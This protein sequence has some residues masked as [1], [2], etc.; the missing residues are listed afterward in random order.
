MTDLMSDERAERMRRDYAE[1]QA[2]WLARLD[3]AKLEGPLDGRERALISAAIRNVADQ[4]MAD[5][6][7]ED[8]RFNHDF[9]W[10]GQSLAGSYPT[11]LIISDARGSIYVPMT[12]TDGAVR[13]D[14]REQRLSHG[15]SQPSIT[16]QRSLPDAGER[17]AKAF[18]EIF[19]TFSVRAR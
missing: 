1:S 18:E 15:R 17:L 6:R 7:K 11:A 8:P 9:E 16:I 2:K 19:W 5:R 10:S 12:W 14:R 4:K 13:L 3:Q